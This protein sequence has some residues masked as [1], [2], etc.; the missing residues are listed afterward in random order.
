MLLDP[1]CY[2]REMLVLLSNIVLLT[3]VD[4]IDNGLRREE[5]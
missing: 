3:K 1:L 4:E 5:E 2:F